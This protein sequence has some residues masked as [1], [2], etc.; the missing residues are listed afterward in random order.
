MNL[1][2]EQLAQFLPDPRTIRQF[3]KMMSLVSELEPDTLS[4]LSLIAG[5]AE[6]KAN[7]ALAQLTRIADALDRQPPAQKDNSTDYIDFG[8]GPSVEQQRRVAWDSEDGTVKIGMGYDGVVQSVGLR[9]YYRIK[10]SAAITKGQLVMFDGAVGAS[11]VLKGKPA[12][13]LTTGQLVMGVAAMDIA[14]NGFGFVTE[15]GLVRNINT[16][17][18]SVGET[19][20]DGD[21]LYY[22]PAYTGGLTKVQPLAPLPH[23]ICASVIN[24]SAGSGSLFVRVTFL[25]KVS[26]LTD[27]NVSSVGV[28]DVLMWDA[29]D[30][31]WENQ[32]P[33]PGYVQGRGLGGTVTQLT[34][35]S[36]AVTLDKYSGVIVT[37]NAALAGGASVAFTLG[38]I[39][40]GA[41]DV[42]VVNTQNTNY[43]ATAYGITSGFVGIRLTN[44]TGG[45]LS[46]AVNINFSIIPGTST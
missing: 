42:V 23:V 28:G 34:S 12:T 26:Q 15:F 35:K 17:G 22:N 43:L 9:T 31:R 32:Y 45:S 30:Q 14:N 44:L 24:A 41:Y 4:M 13:G 38:S 37:N 27:V 46:D 5:G 36:T 21:I 8:L 25:P 3:E 33:L 18:S 39:H 6:S 7:E 2:R 1:T 29:V 19:W 16:T 40:I 20:S 11:G 10:A